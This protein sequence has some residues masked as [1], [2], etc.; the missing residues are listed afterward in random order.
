MLGL[1]YVACEE[2]G[3]VTATA[4]SDADPVCGR[5]ESVAVRTLDGDTDADSDGGVTYFASSMRVE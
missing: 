1:R 2:C 3:R 4:V 5:C